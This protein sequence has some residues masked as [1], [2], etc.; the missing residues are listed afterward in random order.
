MVK[1][2]VLFIAIFYKE[3]DDYKSILL[4]L[5]ELYGKIYEE[6]K[7]YDFNF[8]SYYDNEMGKN[9]KIRTEQTFDIQRKVIAYGTQNSTEIPHAAGTYRPDVTKFLKVYKE[10]QNLYNS[11][12]FSRNTK[13][14]VLKI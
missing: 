3:I 8:T 2:S 14:N 13:T 6:S 5:E 4:K 11:E 9:L 7:P 12:N 1:D 10:F